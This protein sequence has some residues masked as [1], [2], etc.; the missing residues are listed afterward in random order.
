MVLDCCI[1]I[2]STIIS[3]MMNGVCCVYQQ[4]EEQKLREAIRQDVRSEYH[5]MFREQHTNDQQHVVGETPIPSASIVVDHSMDGEESVFIISSLHIQ[6]ECRVNLMKEQGRVKSAQPV[7][8]ISLA[9]KNTFDTNP[10]TLLCSESVTCFKHDEMS[11]PF[12]KFK[13]NHSNVYMKNSEME[14][15]EFEE[16]KEVHQIITASTSWTTVSIV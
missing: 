6:E 4:N 5:S 12:I 2:T 15:N 14:A 8:T 16:D 11:S 10:P 3:I 13:K 7:S 1:T 9:S